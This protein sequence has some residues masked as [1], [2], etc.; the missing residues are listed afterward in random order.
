VCVKSINDLW[1]VQKVFID[2]FQN[3]PINRRG[4]RCCSPHLYSTLL[5]LETI[6]VQSQKVFSKFRLSSDLPP[7]TRFSFLE[8]PHAHNLH[9]NVAIIFDNSPHTHKLSIF[10]IIHIVWLV[11]WNTLVIHLYIS[12]CIYVY[13]FYI[14]CF[15]NYFLDVFKS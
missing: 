3:L 11:N 14:F 2:F 13:S 15:I 12:K 4:K 10:E 6:A 7:L 8:Q 1:Q 9:Q 5:Y